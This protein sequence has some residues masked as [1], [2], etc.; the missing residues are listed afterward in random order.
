MD[1]VSRRS[2][3]FDERCLESKI[4]IVR[5]KLGGCQVPRPTWQQ[6][7]TTVDHLWLIA[8]MYVNYY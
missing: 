8:A 6:Q 5:R 4:L 7:L 3:Q 1:P 2:E